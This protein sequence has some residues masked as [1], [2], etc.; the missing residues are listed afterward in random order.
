MVNRTLATAV[1]NVAGPV[2]LGWL[3]GFIV[4]TIEGGGW[5]KV[6]LS[7]CLSLKYWVC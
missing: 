4:R 3:N 2:L 5:I 6:F 7:F 1:K